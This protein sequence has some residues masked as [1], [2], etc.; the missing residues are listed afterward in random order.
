MSVHTGEFR[1]QENG[2]VKLCSLDS[3]CPAC[4]NILESFLIM[5]YHRYSHHIRE[6]SGMV[7]KL[8][9]HIDEN[10]P[11]FSIDNLK[12]RL[13]NLF[14]TLE[15]GLLK[16]LQ[17]KRIFIYFSFQ[18]VDLER[19]NKVIIHLISNTPFPLRIIK[20]IKKSID[21]GIARMTMEN[22]GF[23]LITFKNFRQNICQTS[24]LS[25]K[26]IE[27]SNLPIP[28]REQLTILTQTTFFPFHLTAEGRILSDFHRIQFCY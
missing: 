23:N 24:A 7:L 22:S 9:L 11:R 2:K 12:V 6:G 25:R 4:G 26:H 28:I 5:R 21:S 20:S 18:S 15:D 10:V 16:Q 1:T 13:E 8:A 27:L 3:K 19:E 14:L 17:K